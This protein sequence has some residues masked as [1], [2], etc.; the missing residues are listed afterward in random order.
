[1]YCC[2]DSFGFTSEVG[3]DGAEGLRGALRLSSCPYL[4]YKPGAS[5]I[6]T[7]VRDLICRREHER[8]RVDPLLAPG[9]SRIY[10]QVAF[11]CIHFTTEVDP[12]RRS[13]WG[14]ASSKSFCFCCFFQVCL[15]VESTNTTDSTITT[16]V[17]TRWVRSCQSD[18][19]WVKMKSRN[20]V[21]MLKKF[22]F[23]T[24]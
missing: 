13:N 11:R 3:K 16:Q 4:V 12:K 6:I 10:R 7:T 2:W 9:H 17:N 14:A 20:F 5:T 15:L 1:M 19:S 21:L 24:T 22:K 8:C 18:A 23:K